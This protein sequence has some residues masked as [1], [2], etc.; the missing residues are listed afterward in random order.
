MRFCYLR[1]HFKPLSQ[2]FIIFKTPMI[3]H[4]VHLHLQEAIPKL[5]HSTNPKPLGSLKHRNRTGLE[6]DY[7]SGSENLLLRQVM[8]WSRSLKARGYFSFYFFSTIY[9]KFCFIC[10]KYFL[11]KKLDFPVT[12]IYELF[13]WCKFS[14]QF[15]LIDI[16]LCNL[17]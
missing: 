14:N 3:H 7:L 5:L 9:L 10:L 15:K 4:K 6:R 8:A 13:S 12:N 16:F 2:E 1:D 11:V 17:K